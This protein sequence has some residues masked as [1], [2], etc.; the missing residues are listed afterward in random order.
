MEDSTSAARHGLDPL[1]FVPYGAGGTEV[2]IYRGGASLVL[3]LAQQARTSAAWGGMPM[4]HTPRSAVTTS[5]CLMPVMR[6]V[7]SFGWRH[8]RIPVRFWIT[9]Y[10]RRDPHLRQASEEC[11]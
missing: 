3:Q 1:V 4:A 7:V 9:P 8:T 6:L 5:V 10:F 2:K 11:D